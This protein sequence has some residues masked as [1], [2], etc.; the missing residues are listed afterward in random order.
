LNNGIDAISNDFT[1]VNE[2]KSPQSCP[3]K[4]YPGN[5]GNLALSVLSGIECCNIYD[6]PSECRLHFVSPANAQKPSSRPLNTWAKQTTTLCVG[7]H[8]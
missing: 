8:L 4:R 5:P 2:E 1:S 3:G 6:S 7:I